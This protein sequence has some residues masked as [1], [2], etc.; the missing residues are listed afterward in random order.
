MRGMVIHT[1]LP[2][3]LSTALLAG[4]GMAGPG[5]DAPKL[6]DF[7][8]SQHGFRFVNSFQGAPLSGALGAV[9]SRFTGGSYG[10]CGGM[11]ALAA[12][13]YLEQH[14]VPPDS[15]PPAA[16]TELYQRLLGRQVD[17]LDGL[18]LP[19]QYARWMQLADGGPLGT[20]A[21]T[22]WGL[23]CVQGEILGNKP[24][25]VG[26]V[27]ASSG[28][29]RKIWENHQVLGYWA[30]ADVQTGVVTVRIYDPNHPGNDEA[31]LVATPRVEGVTVSPLGLPLIAMGYEVRATFRAGDAGRV[32]RG[33]F[34]MPYERGL[35]E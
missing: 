7:R 2:L 31:R 33:V 25:I 22:W 4:F 10:L 12:D 26:E 34:L 24:G 13:L 20:R 29:G 21:M 30:A 6:A 23:A 18:R 5:D 11:S 3:A 27:L 16:G 17:S 32:V 9:A 8:P 35:R 1:L 15:K 19:E 14:S 28:N